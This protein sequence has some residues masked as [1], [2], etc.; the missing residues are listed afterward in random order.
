LHCNIG[1]KV[2]YQDHAVAGLIGALNSVAFSAQA[3][4]LLA[5]T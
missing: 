4:V 1:I 3:L 5:A 2:L